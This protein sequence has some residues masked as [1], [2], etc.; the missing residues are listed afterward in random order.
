LPVRLESGQ[1]A[2]LDHLARG[3]SVAEAAKAAGL[4]RGTV[5]RWLKEDPAFQAAYNR[6]LDELEEGSRTQLLT[7]IFDAARFASRCGPVMQKLRCNYSRDL[8]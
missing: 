7:M 8:A 1:R 4:N 5:Y 2:A 6:W 3:K